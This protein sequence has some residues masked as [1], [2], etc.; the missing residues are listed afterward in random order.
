MKVPGSRDQSKSFHEIRELQIRLLE[1]EEALAAIRGGD[2]DAIVVSGPGG[3]RIF[4]LTGT[5]QIYRGI[6]ET[7]SEAA[8]TVSFDGRVLYANSQLSELLGRPLEQMVGCRLV[9]LAVPADHAGLEGFLAGTG[10]G[11]VRGRFSF[12]GAR[13]P[14]PLRLSGSR[15]PQPDGACACIVASDLSE[16]ESTSA[17]LTLMREQQ[18]LLQREAVRRELLRR[19]ASSLLRSDDPSAVVTPLCRELLETLDCQLFLLYEAVPDG[20]SLQL[21]AHEGLEPADVARLATIPRDSTLCGLVAR[22]STRRVQNADDVAGDR[23]ADHLRSLELKAY[24]CFPLAAGGKVMGT[25]SFG[26]RTRPAFEESEVALLQTIADQVAIA[27]DRAGAVSG[28]R[29]ANE[30]LEQRVAQRT[31]ALDRSARQLRSLVGQLSLAEQREQRRLAGVLHDD[32]QQLLAVARL[33]AGSLLG[34]GAEALQSAVPKLEEVLKQ[35][36]GVTRTL[37]SDLS[38]PRGRDGGLATVFRWLAD[39]M[40]EKHGLAVTYRPEGE[41][42]AAADDAVTL[43]QQSV[44]ELL[45]N[46][47]KHAGV[48]A[49]ELSVTATADALRIRVSDAGTGFDPR[50]LGAEAGQMSFGLFSIQ[51]RL[52]VIGG[53][54]VVDSAPGAGSRLELVVPRESL[55]SAA[56]GTAEGADRW[57]PGKARVLVVE[58]HPVTREAIDLMLRREPGISVAGVAV[59]GLE[60]VRKAAE[61]APDVVI[62]D[63]NLPGIDGVEATRAIVEK[64]PAVKVIGY[65]MRDEESVGPALREAGAVAFVSKTAPASALVDA[66]RRCC[67]PAADPA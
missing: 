57:A 41:I 23:R 15:L 25:L 64:S 34:A 9:D 35:C 62:M 63:L 1:A 40:R 31:A 43:I 8:M 67:P 16:L 12:A 3:E 42:P 61:L 28:L 7:M 66:I 11:L 27:M 10:T 51:E 55:R 60:A 65:S 36:I 54:L 30:E 45:F 13:A 24:A 37:S 59:D 26:T 29:T 33:Q 5:D 52:G 47:V 21:V 39:W 48:T 38:P 2:V 6:V 58:D 56:T 46:V 22:E 50:T 44:R 32:L 4:S 53:R 20:T 14:V 17:V 19:A 18:E 49:A